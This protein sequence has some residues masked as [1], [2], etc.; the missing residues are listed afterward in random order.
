[1]MHVMLPPPPS[2]DLTGT[3]FAGSNNTPIVCYLDVC[4]CPRSLYFSEVNGALPGCIWEPP[5]RQTLRWGLLCSTPA[6]T[7]AHCHCT[8]RGCRGAPP[9]PSRSSSPSRS[10]RTPG[11]SG[12]LRCTSRVRLV[13]K[14]T[15]WIRF[16][17]CIILLVGWFRK[18]F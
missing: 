4:R 6:S 3:S 2:N 9:G 15:A 16:R 8:S 18:V 1:M 11:A 7:R 5:S 10:R 12:H 17:F 14:N 13:C